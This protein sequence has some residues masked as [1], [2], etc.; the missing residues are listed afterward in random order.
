MTSLLLSVQEQF[1][2]L[3]KCNS[4]PVEVAID[5][6]RLPSCNRIIDISVL[7]DEE[8]AGIVYSI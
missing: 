7:I 3:L 5:A 6:S 1:H 4:V 8:K 2:V